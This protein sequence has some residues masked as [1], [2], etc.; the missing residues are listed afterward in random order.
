[1]KHRL[2]N[3]V[4]AFTLPVGVYI[5]FTILTGGMFGGMTTFLSIVRTSIVP[6]LLGMSLSFGM[7][8]DMWNFAAG[9]I[10]YNAAIFSANIAKAM[11][12]GIPGIILFAIL[13]A[14]ISNVIIGIAYNL[15][16][17]PC[18]V[19]S[20]GFAMIYEALPHFL[21]PESMGRIG[22]LDGWM[23]DLPWCLIVVGV[24][25]ALFYFINNYTTLGANINAIGANIAIANNAGVGIDRVKFLSFLISGF[26]LGITG[27][28]YLF[29][30][31]S[32][33]A[34]TGF[35]SVALIFDSMMGIFVAVVL[36]KY[37]NYSTAV[38]IGVFTIRM[39]GT[40]LV[41]FG[42]SSQMRGVMTGLFLLVVLVYSANAGMIERMRTKKAI[43][44]EADAAYQMRTA[45]SK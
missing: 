16:R 22:I 26:F 10:I 42:M 1:M 2:I 40:A 39:L 4:K 31:V 44:R 35:T 37:V 36:A 13:V 28:M 7:S 3:Y 25:F 5:L 41:A 32:V 11:G 15:F 6:V 19:L 12:L 43:A 14:V 9:A 18:M 20:L 34:V 30:N 29:V 17:V 38:V 24:M 21:A 27:A 45:Q 8:M 33:Q 23:S